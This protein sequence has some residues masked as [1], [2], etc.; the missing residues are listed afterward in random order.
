MNS[1]PVIKPKVATPALTL[2]SAAVLIFVAYFAVAIATSSPL[3]GPFLLGDLA[4]LVAVVVLGWV[5]LVR[6]RRHTAWM[7]A[8]REKWNQFDDAK[9][10][11]RTTTEVTVVSVDALEPTGS[12]ITINWNRFNHVQQAWIEALPEPIWPGSV[13]LISP[14]PDQVGPGAPWPQTYYIQAPRCL[15]WAPT[16]RP[17]HFGKHGLNMR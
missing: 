11:H 5:W 8:A 2:A 4:A 7:T 12:W 14:D 10:T 3:S 17:G 1:N 15:A 16:K 13:L 6:S 9:R